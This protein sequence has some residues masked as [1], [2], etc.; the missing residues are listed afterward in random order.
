MSLYSWDLVYGLT[1]KALNRKLARIFYQ[2]R[3]Q[4]H[5]IKQIVAMVIDP[6]HGS[7]T[8]SYIAD[9]VAKGTYAK[10]D[11]NGSAIPPPELAVSYFEEQLQQQRLGPGL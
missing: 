10:M 6:A 3:N 1:Y 9:I 5:K 2:Q 8:G 11:G 7:L 4:K